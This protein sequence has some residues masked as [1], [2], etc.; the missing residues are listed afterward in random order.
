MSEAEH[1]KKD[2]ISPESREQ[3]LDKKEDSVSHSGDKPVD[4]VGVDKSEPVIVDAE[5][6]KKGKL[7]TLKV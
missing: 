6:V 5:P 7:D 3:I 1:N 2:E 4:Q